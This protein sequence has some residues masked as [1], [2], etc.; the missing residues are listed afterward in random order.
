ML[1]S[2]T[3]SLYSVH[4]RPSDIGYP[5]RI[6]FVHEGF[7]FSAF[8]FGAFWALYHG[9]WRWVAIL[10]AIN[11]LFGWAAEHAVLDSF[12]LAVLQLSVQLIFGYH[13]N[14]LWRAHLDRKGFVMTALS[15]GESQMRAEQRFFDHHASYLGAGRA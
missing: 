15:S 12:S 1:R 10:L 6:R 14:D 4:I 5:D 3:L 13:A 2:H 8:V 11:A 7:N 9:L